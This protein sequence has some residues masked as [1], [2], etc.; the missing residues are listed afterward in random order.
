MKKVI[1]GLSL[2]LLFQLGFAQ[3]AAV[4]QKGNGVFVESLS[5]NDN[6]LK[7]VD[8]LVER[9]NEWSYWQVETDKEDADFMLEVAISASKGITATS[10]GG[11][12]YELVAKLVDK[13]D[14]VIWESNN[15]KASPNGTNGFNAGR[16]VVKKLVRDLKKKYK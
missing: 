11:T 4:T 10:W 12:S 3:D 6:A 9:L 13:S 2:F 16:S 7:T 14:A 1:F 15:Y 5:K 8:E